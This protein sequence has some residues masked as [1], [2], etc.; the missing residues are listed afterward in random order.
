MQSF[1]DRLRAARSACGKTQE[2]VAAEVGVTKATVSSWENNRDT[3]SFQY[4]A[5]LRVAVATSLDELICEDI[6]KGRAVSRAFGV[7]DEEGV[8]RLE[9]TARAQSA[10]EYALLQRF[11]LMTPERQRGLLD[12]LKPD[13]PG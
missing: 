1:G 6:A 3:P 12:V 10:H 8:Y 11:R 5:P 9:D 7:R 2:V 4:L 13:K